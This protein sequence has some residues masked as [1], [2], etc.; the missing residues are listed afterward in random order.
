MT[1]TQY[2]SLIFANESQFQAATFR[3][4][5]NNYAKT[6]GLCFHV[7]NESIS[8]DLMRLKLKSMGLVAGIPDIVCI[9]PAMGLELKMPNGKQSNKQKHIQKVWSDANIP[10]AVCYNAIEVCLFLE[11]VLT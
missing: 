8:S 2:I 3:Y 7:A 9:K 4:I 10:F 11:S 1:K 5:N 6:R